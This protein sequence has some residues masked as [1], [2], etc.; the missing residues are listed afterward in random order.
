MEAIGTVN[1]RRDH[2]AV[3]AAS[4]EYRT[5]RQ[6]IRQAR[7]LRGRSQG[8]VARALG[9]NRASVSMWETGETE[10]RPQRLR[11]LARFLTVD[12]EWL[13]FGSGN[14][15]DGA[16]PAIRLEP[17]AHVFVRGLVQAGLWREAFEWPRDEWFPIPAP[18]SDPRYPGVERFG[19][20]VRGT[21]MNVLYP[22]DTVLICVRFA[23]I[24]RG[25]KSGERVVVQRVDPAGAIEATVKEF[26]RHEDGSLWLWPRSHDPRFQSPY[27]L[28]TAGGLQEVPAHFEGLRPDP[29]PATAVTAFLRTEPEAF[30]ILAL[31]I[32]SYRPE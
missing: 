5:M 7:K 22:E 20:L 8:D 13:I 28:K 10:P 29:D 15:P 16:A 30:D 6:R 23:D 25:P 2:D 4:A 9:V 26:V 24:G 19:L 3:P 21:S 12:P 11:D 17:V 27:Q 1:D 14:P 31:V 32:G 18:H